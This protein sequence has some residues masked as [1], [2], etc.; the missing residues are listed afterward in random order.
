MWRWTEYLTALL[1]TAEV[2]SPGTIG[3]LTINHLRCS[4]VSGL[5]LVVVASSSRAMPVF[6]ACSVPMTP[7]SMLVRV[8]SL[9]RGA[10]TSSI[11]RPA[12]NRAC[13]RSVRMF[14]FAAWSVWW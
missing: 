14:A 7:A 6:M 3:A 13:R 11:A 4:S 2:T 12:R 8:R 10:G 1:I 9:I 5:T